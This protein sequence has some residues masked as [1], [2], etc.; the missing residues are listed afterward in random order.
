MFIFVFGFVC[1]RVETNLEGTMTRL[2]VVMGFVTMPASG[3]V[4]VHVSEF[5]LSPNLI[6]DKKA[7]RVL[8]LIYRN[9]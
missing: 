8:G 5:D 4:F 6:F 1:T 7:E 3:L 9:S 2:V